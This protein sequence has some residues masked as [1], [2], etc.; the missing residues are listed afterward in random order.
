MKKVYFSV[1]LCLL[2]YAGI[3][4]TAASYNFSRSSGT[5]ASISGGTGTVTLSDTAA[6]T[7]GEG[8]TINSDDEGTTG[9][10]I[11]FTFNFCGTNYTTC[12]GDANGVISLSG[13]IASYIQST[14]NIN[15][16]GWLMPFWR[17][18]YGIC[19]NAYYQTSG[20]PGSRVFTLEWNNWGICCST[21]SASMYFQV[22]LFEGTNNIQ[23]CYGSGTGAVP[24][25]AVI[26]IAN[27]SSDYQTMPTETATSPNT[28]FNATCTFPASGTILQWCPPITTP[29][30]ITGNL[31]VCTSGGTTTLNETTTGGTWSTS[32]IAIATVGTSGVVTGVTA[33]ADTVSYTITNGCISLSSMVSVTIDPLPV[34]SGGS[35]VAICNGSSTTL[36]G[37][38]GDAYSWSPSYGLSC[39]NCV[40]PTANPTVTTTYTVT[41]TTYYG[42]V[43]PIVY[44]QSFTNGVTPSTQCTVWDAFRA[45][46]LGTYNYSGFTMRGSMNTTG[47]SCTDP[48]VASAVANALRTG[49]TYSGVSDGQTW[50]V[51][52][53]CTS[54]P[55]GTIA[56]ELSNNGSCA[57]GNGYTVRP[58]INNNNWGGI[59]GP[60]CNAASQT[61]EVVFYS[62][63]GCNSSAMVTVSVNPLPNMYDVT[64]GGSY[65]AG[66]A[67][68]I[69]GLDSSNNG[70]RYQL[71]DGVTAM[72]SPVNGIDTAIS[73]GLD[74]AAGVYTVV[75]TDT[76]TGCTN[77]MDGSVTI[78]ITPLVHPSVAI[79]RST[80]DTICAGTHTTFTTDETNGGPTPHYIW[81]VNGSTVGP[82]SFAYNYMPTT[83]NRVN[84]LMVSDAICPSPDT[85]SSDTLT[86]IV[87]PNG[88]PTVHLAASPSDTVCEGTTVTINPTVTFGG[89]GPIYTWVKNTVV[90]S[91]SSSYTFTPINGDDIYAVMTSN[92]MCRLAT[93][94]YSNVVAMMVEAPVVPAV[95][96]TAYP[97]LVIQ[98]GT[99]DSFYA[100]VTGGALN[101]S[102]QWYLN[103]TAV[104]GATN[105]FFRRT[106]FH[107]HDSISCMVT[108]NDACALST[109]NSVV[110]NVHNLG[111]QTLTGN[112]DVALI[113]N[114]NK[115]VFSL[116][117]S[118]AL[119][120]DEEVSVEVTNMLGQTVYRNKFMTRNGNIDAQ[121]QAEGLASGSYLLTMRSS[122]GSSV[123]HFVIEK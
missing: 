53:G 59:D 69:I 9:I 101:P 86:M 6:C 26:G 74:T 99:P 107:N 66:G 34:V 93:L 100:T 94:A 13:N 82:D 103:D 88:T 23:F 54:G 122:G 112:G 42:G 104:P 106:S 60:T 50:T 29:G 102:Y 58:S 8:S 47:I 22:K 12:A 40:S 61:M 62:G 71:Y 85:V 89:Y 38:G 3:A 120:S 79:F 123:F 67:G 105:S 36:T 48:A 75:A 119:L 72:G 25:T 56:V 37:T 17:D 15:G 81:K 121:I 115:G 80:S 39:T 64:G 27:S 91:T 92:Y 73:F 43:A 51:G 78:T 77:T 32:N 109:I 7:S 16:A 96:I 1:V 110:L 44:S 84:V 4:Q 108:R 2:G 49:T 45:S 14:G 31:N 97:G 30:A 19:K 116:K 87:F 68:R 70:I 113:P 20:T 114:P 52:I 11:G 76:T 83:G 33:G 118:L 98:T 111:V 5:F 55:C 117:G 90:V 10:P 46:L 95:T 57:C 21:T 35:N 63:T 18:L 65:C 41:G 24:T 28:S